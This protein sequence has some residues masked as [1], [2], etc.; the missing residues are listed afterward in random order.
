VRLV[1]IEG[2]TLLIEDV[3]VVDGTPLLDIKPYV[4]EFDARKT[5]KIGWLTGKAENARTTRS[6]ERFK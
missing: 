1:A 2:T 6:D 3:D 5:E 4:P